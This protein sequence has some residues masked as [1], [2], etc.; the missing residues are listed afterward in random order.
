MKPLGIVAIVIAI[1]IG[2]IVIVVLAVK[3]TPPDPVVPNA[4]T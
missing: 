1:I 2:L 4:P 3:L